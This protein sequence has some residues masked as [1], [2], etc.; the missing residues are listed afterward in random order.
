LEILK[1]VVYI[2]IL[3]LRS[4]NTEIEYIISKVVEGKEE[5]KYKLGTVAYTCNSSCLGG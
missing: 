4:R 5:R 1:E 2:K 3:R